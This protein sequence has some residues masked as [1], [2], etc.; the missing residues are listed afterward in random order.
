[1]R[2]RAKGRGQKERALRAQPFS[3][4][5]GRLRGKE[6]AQDELS[7]ELAWKKRATI[8]CAEEGSEA[9]A[10]LHA[11]FKLRCSVPALRQ[12]LK[13]FGKEHVLTS[14][15]ILFSIS[16]LGALTAQRGRLEGESLFS[17]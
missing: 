5:R 4:S 8:F 16:Q 12:G 10:Q 13:V 2:K 3:H 11:F 9:Q 17:L 1:M 15:R 7:L 14:S 6:G